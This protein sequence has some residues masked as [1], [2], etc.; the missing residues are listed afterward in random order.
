MTT[1]IQKWGNSLALR[2]PKSFAHT[3]QIKEGSEIKLSIEKNK[4]VISKKV[5]PKY[6]LKD[7][8]SKVTPDNIHKEIN[9]GPPRGKELL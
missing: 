2:I 4:I 8:L 6:T 3:T 7:L 1:K 9:F 5:K